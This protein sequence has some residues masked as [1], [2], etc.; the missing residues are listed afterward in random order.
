MKQEDPVQWSQAFQGSEHPETAA[1]HVKKSYVDTMISLK[2]ENME[3]VYSYLMGLMDKAKEELGH[4]RSGGSSAEHRKLALRGH[5]DEIFA[6]LKGQALDV[7][8]PEKG[9]DGHFVLDG[10]PGFFGRVKCV[11][12]QWYDS[13]LI[14]MYDEMVTLT[15]LKK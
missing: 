7:A 11:L 1:L 8:A 9:E 10:V 15:N 14:A 3:R 6:Y 13:H 4:C 12:D 2:R 5:I